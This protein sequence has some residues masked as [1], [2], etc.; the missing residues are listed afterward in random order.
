MHAELRRWH[1]RIGL[2]AALLVLLVAITG[3]LINHSD[4]LRLGE[5]RLHAPWLQRLYGLR[6][7][8]LVAAHRLHERWLIQWDRQ[9][10]VD[11]RASAARDVEQM[12]GAFATG[13]A[14]VVAD[15]T[16]LWLLT[17]DGKLIDRVAFPTDFVAVDAGA[18]SG[19]VVLRSA[20]GRIIQTDPALTG[21]GPA[22]PDG[23]R[24][25]ENRPPPADVV[26]AHAGQVPG[27]GL[28]VERLLLDVH[29]GRWMG[30]AGTLL[31]D[32]SAVAMLFLAVSGTLGAWR[33]R[34][35]P[36]TRRRERTRGDP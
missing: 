35:H 11:G 36:S 22:R 7:P 14:W 1:R 3:V 31:I 30:R 32:L 18:S 8:T 25:A 34:R 6:P 21:F 15:R 17:P 9:I 19:A 24:W 29:S 12:L 33:A 10:F 5:R 2:A 26:A 23:V 27:A 13:E 28:S 4:S 16:Q 20:D